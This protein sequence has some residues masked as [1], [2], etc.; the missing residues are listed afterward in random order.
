MRE[1]WAR[2]PMLLAAPMLAALLLVAPAPASTLASPASFHVRGVEVSASQTKGRF[3]G[4]VSA[5][6]VRGSW[7]AIVEHVALGPRPAAI[8]GGS[9]RMATID[10]DLSPGVLRASFSGGTVSLVDPG[11][12]CTKQTF[13]VHGRLAGVST[14]TSSD[15]SGVLDATL[16]HYRRSL[17]GRCLTYAAS[18]SG[19]AR[20]SY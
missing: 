12:G 13:A 18:V 11:R 19:S 2:V 9:L 14:R 7:V 6:G 10:R 5:A 4:T 3:V 1:A 8:T 16:T 15:G 17:L 20:F